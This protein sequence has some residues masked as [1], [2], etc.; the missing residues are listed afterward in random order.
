MYIYRLQ[1]KD[2]D[3][4]NTIVTI[5]LTLVKPPFSFLYRY[6]SESI[7]GQLLNIYWASEQT[8]EKSG[9]KT[10]KMSPVKATRRAMAK[11]NA[12]QVGAK[13]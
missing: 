3:E 9:R 13:T 1:F 5:D 11:F 10:S 2:Y 6:G 8:N 7:S 12:S 4:K